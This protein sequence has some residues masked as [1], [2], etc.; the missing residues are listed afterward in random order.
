MKTLTLPMIHLNGTGAETLRDNYLDASNAVREAMDLC[1][2]V[3]FNARDYYPLGEG[4]YPK[5]RDEHWDRITRLQ[6]VR[7]ELAA[8]AYHVQTIMDDKEARRLEREKK[9]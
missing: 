4:A 6:D 9:T 3:E 1:Q 2:K 7:E 5:A 8:I